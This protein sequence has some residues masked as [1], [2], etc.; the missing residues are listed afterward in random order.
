[1]VTVRPRAPEA[2]KYKA[3]PGF[4]MI[5]VMVMGLKEL[6]SETWLMSVLP[7]LTLTNALAAE[8]MLVSVAAAK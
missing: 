2:E 4:K 7:P 3:L 1:M 8:E 6:V 5:G